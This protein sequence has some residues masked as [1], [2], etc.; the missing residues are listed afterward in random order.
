MLVFNE[1]SVLRREEG[2]LYSCKM[3]FFFFCRLIWAQSPTLNAFHFTV[4]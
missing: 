1:K 3:L 2:G 4:T